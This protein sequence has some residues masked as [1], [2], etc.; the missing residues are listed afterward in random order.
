[1]WVR[2]GLEGGRW[3]EGDQ[4]ISGG[5]YRVRWRRDGRAAVVGSREETV[6]LPYLVGMDALA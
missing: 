2:K 1:V 3:W 5:L 6:V 4:R